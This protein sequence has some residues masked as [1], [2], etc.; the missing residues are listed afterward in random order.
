MSIVMSVLSGILT[1]VVLSPALVVYTV[2]TNGKMTK[3]YFGFN[4]AAIIYAI[5]MGYSVAF[6]VIIAF[7]LMLMSTMMIDDLEDRLEFKLIPML[8]AESIIVIT[9]GLK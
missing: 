4:V 3:A 8:I 2:A 6:S 9:C 5:C 1:S 7:V